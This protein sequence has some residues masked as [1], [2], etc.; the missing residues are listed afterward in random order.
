MYS[1]NKLA[2]LSE[3]AREIRI[4][5]LEQ[6]ATRGF[7]HLGGCMS[8]VEIVAVLYGAEM[9]YDPLNPRQ[10]ERDWLICSKGHAGPAIYSALAIKGF[11]PL[12][13]LSTLNQPNTNLPSHCD[14]NKTPGID[15]TTGSLGQGLSVAVGVAYGHKLREIEGT[16]IYVIVGDGELQ[17]GQNWEAAMLAAHLGLDNLILLVDS[18][19][20]QL[21]G[22]VEDVNNIQSLDE[23]FAAFNWNVLHIDGHDIGAVGGALAS[24]KECMGKPSV[25]IADTVKGKGIV[26]AEGHFNHHIDISRKNAD[27]ALQALNS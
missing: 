10:E 27:I 22:N 8:I 12:Y 1:Q 26:W 19:K 16:H 2:E 15:I 18:N 11:Y 17:E 7:G 25:I 20:V 14:R 4:Q 13:W 5:T 24:A 23:K 9:K 21:D 3:F 6:M